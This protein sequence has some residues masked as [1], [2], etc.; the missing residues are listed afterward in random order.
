ME[1]FKTQFKMSGVLTYV[2]VE[3][4]PEQ[5]YACTLNLVD[6]FEGGEQPVD[7]QD[8]DMRLKRDEAG[9]WTMLDN[10]KVTL[11]PEDLQRLGEAIDELNI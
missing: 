8:S 7:L 4:L 3:K 1:R 9:Q 6:F 2:T 5:T 11:E 10:A